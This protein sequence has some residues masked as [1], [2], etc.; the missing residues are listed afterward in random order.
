[1]DN[2][3]GELFNRA[4]SKKSALWLVVLTLGV[5]SA[6]ATMLFLRR[7]RPESPAK[8]PDVLAQ[9]RFR[10][11]DAL[12]VELVSGKCGSG[13]AFVTVFDVGVEHDPA[14]RSGMAF[15]LGELLSAP[16]EAGHPARVVDVGSDYTQYSVAL[17]PAQIE[18]E[19]GVIAERM[20]RLG[21]DQAAL[22]RARAKVLAESKLRRGGDPMVTAMAHAAESMSA[23]RAQGHFGG[24][25]S[26]I[27]AIQLADVEAYWREHYQLAST[28]VVVLG[29][30]D[31]KEIQARIEQL[32][33]HLPSGSRASLRPPT[34]S[35][36]RGTLV[37]GDTPKAIALGVP[38]PLPKEP[39]YPAFLV[40]AAR[41]SQGPFAGGVKYEPFAR[42]EN[43]F[44]LHSLAAGEAPEPTAEKLKADVVKHLSEP[45]SAQD[46]ETTK[47]RFASLL[48]FLS[49]DPAFCKKDPLGVAVARARGAQLGLDPGALERAIDELTQEQFGQ[50]REAFA[51]ARMSA[52]IAGGE[53]R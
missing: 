14:G 7:E 16:S 3:G 29:Q 46:I 5:L 44:V 45:L 32:F 37:M 41:L 22:E 35:S 1:V 48:G 28:R 9:K 27:E 25:P 49:S 39:A 53:I 38:A 18:G 34:G 24:I 11:S 30:F 40:L 51:P 6:A 42:P 50:A 4:M 47:A 15:L 23:S 8:P 10:V 36:V 52:V 21:V 13:A 19:L 31:E 43:L 12:E 26:E 20:T 17:T 33:G 2:R